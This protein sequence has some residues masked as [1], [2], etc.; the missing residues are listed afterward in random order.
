MKNKTNQTN[1]KKYLCMRQM[2]GEEDESGFGHFLAIFDSFL[3][4][5]WKIDQMMHEDIYWKRQEIK[6]YDKHDEE[7]GDQYLKVWQ[8]TRE[9][10]TL[11]EVNQDGF[12]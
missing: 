3:L 1:M 6:R 10:I 5:E 8:G 11:R 7:T 4:G 2:I 9:K 12:Y